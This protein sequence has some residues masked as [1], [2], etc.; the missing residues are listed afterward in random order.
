ML[1]RRQSPRISP[2]RPV[3]LDEPAQYRVGLELMVAHQSQSS[4]TCSSHYYIGWKRRL[5][6]KLKNSTARVSKRLSYLSAAC[7]RARYCFRPFRYLLLNCFLHLRLFP[8]DELFHL[9]ARFR[10]VLFQQ[11]TGRV[12]VALAAEF[13]QGA[14]FVLGVA[15]GVA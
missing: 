13:E 14:V 6:N 10:N 9:T 11:A 12:R 7:L 8:L 5:R 4:H 15:M 3:A 2:A 1:G